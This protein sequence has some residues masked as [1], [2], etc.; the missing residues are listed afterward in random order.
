M[1]P[2]TRWRYRDTGTPP[3]VRLKLPAP[4]LT[5]PPPGTPPA[6]PG[7]TNC[8]QRSHIPNLPAPYEYVHTALPGTQ[9]FNPDSYAK[10][11]KHNED[12]MPD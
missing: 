8:A 3:Q 9:L 4:E 10:D 2:Q 6:P 5:P 7:H 11:R 12:F 1:N